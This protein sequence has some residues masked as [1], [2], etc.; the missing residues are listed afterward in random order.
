MKKF[1]ALGPAFACLTLCASLGLAQAQPD[2]NAP[3]R[4]Q[5]PNPQKPDDSPQKVWNYLVA[6]VLFGLVLGA[7]MIPSKRGHQD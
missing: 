3:P 6:L 5:P 2:P 7:V 4:P 1:R